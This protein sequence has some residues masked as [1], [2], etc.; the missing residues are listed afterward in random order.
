MLLE[1]L[2][3]LGG[4]VERR[5]RE[6]RQRVAEVGREFGVDAVADTGTANDVEQANVLV[7]VPAA[8]QRVAD[9]LA[10]GAALIVGEH[11]MRAERGAQ[12]VGAER[13]A[14]LHQGE[15]D[16]GSAIGEKPPGGDTVGA[17]VG[18]DPAPAHEVLL[19]PF[20]VLRGGTGEL[21]PQVPHGLLLVAPRQHPRAEHS[22]L[23]ACRID[24]PRVGI[25][26]EWQQHV[27]RGRL[28]GAV[29][30]A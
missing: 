4:V 26:E 10:I 15:V 1:V 30:A 25:D 13:N 28:A 18:L 16:P 8:E 3:R 23:L 2:Q 24:P 21:D 29:D 20:F 19:A 12:H 5:L 27:H 11:G 9:R 6:L 7:E 22:G 17:L 14:A